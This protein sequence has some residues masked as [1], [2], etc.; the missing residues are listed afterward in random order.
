[1]VSPVVRQHATLGRCAPIAVAAGQCGQAD[2]AG[3]R[4]EVEQRD[5]WVDPALVRRDVY[6]LAARTG[7]ELA[8]DVT[9][10]R[11]YGVDR[12]V[13]LIGSLAIAEA[14]RDQRQH[15]LFTLGQRPRVDVGLRCGGRAGKIFEQVTRNRRVDRR[16]TFNRQ[17]NRFG[18]AFCVAVLQ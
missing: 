1:M 13:Q 4:F 11:A 2:A 17:Q 8:V 9:H 18:N 5:P 6:R 14:A 10:V 3:R 16:L 7:F 12:H 15:R